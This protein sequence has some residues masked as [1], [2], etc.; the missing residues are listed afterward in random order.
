MDVMRL[1]GRAREGE[2]ERL[3]EAPLQAFRATDAFAHAAA[4]AAASLGGPG[5]EALRADIVGAVLR[6]GA[7]LLVASESPR[8]SGAEASALEG[9]TRA[10]A[11]TRYALYLARRLGAL[12]L[13]SYRSLAA[14]ADAAAREVR[15]LRE[16]LP[17]P[18]AP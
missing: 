4:R 9:V 13:R 12:D 8:G 3:S 5:G 1:A 18:R 15:A 2:D 10:L 16:R 14:R 11:G 17:S 7:G 6:C